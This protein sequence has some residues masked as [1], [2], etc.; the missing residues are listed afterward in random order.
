MNTIGRCTFCK[1]PFSALG[2]ARDH[3][4]RYHKMPPKGLS[5]R[6]V[7]AHLILP[8]PSVAAVAARGEG[9]NFDSAGLAELLSLARPRNVA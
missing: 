6:V 2:T 5:D 1:V 7:T 8:R 4:V 3:L 9:R